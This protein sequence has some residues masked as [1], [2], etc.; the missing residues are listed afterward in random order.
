MFSLIFESSRPRGP[1]SRVPQSRLPDRLCL[2]AGLGGPHASFSN[3]TRNIS[4]QRAE[5]RLAVQD[6]V[7]DSRAKRREPGKRDAVIPWVRWRRKGSLSR[8]KVHPW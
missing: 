3:R 5:A 4:N 6:T 1:K 8:L 2:V 7:I